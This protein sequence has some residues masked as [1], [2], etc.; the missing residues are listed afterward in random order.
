MINEK[1][2]WQL[3]KEAQWKS[4]HNYRRISREWK[5]LPNDEFEMLKKFI[6]EKADE[7]DKKY[8]D[9]WLGKDGGGGFDV[10]DDGWSDLRYEV[11]GRGE[12]FYN[13]ITVE[14]L[15]EMAEDFDYHESFGYCVLK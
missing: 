6:D 13:S 10:S 14:K 7:L 3:I 12:E 5:T 8:H 4:D 9:A 15:R 2:Y 11:V 1:R